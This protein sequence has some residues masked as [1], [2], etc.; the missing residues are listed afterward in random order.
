MKL[1]SS[2]QK[3]KEAQTAFLTYKQSHADA[4]ERLLHLVN[5]TRQM[6]FKYDY[7]CGLLLNDRAY[8]DRF[9]PHF[10]QRSIIDLYENEVKK[11]SQFSQATVDLQNL[12]HA[13][14]TIGFE[15]LCLL[16]RGKTPEEI[17]GIYSLRKFV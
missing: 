14:Q 12:L 9:M 16:I 8:A 15:N 13:H 5:L 4:F 2:I 3:L 6:Q 10:V 7:L 1:I 11:M 17:K